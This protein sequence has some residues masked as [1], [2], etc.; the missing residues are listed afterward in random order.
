MQQ[1]GSPSHQ[2]REWGLGGAIGEGRLLLEE[3]QEIDEVGGGS[4][5][6]AAVLACTE[7]QRTQ[8]ALEIGRGII[9]GHRHA[10]HRGHR[11]RIERGPVLHRDHAEG[12]AD[13][14]G[15]V[16]DDLRDALPSER[17]AVG[18]LERR[19]SHGGDLLGGVDPPVEQGSGDEVTV[20]ARG[21]HEQPLRLREL[22]A[23]GVLV[24]GGQPGGRMVGQERAGIGGAK[25]E[26]GM[27]GHVARR[28]APAPARSHALHDGRGRKRLF[29]GAGQGGRKQ[30]LALGLVVAWG[31]PR[32][33]RWR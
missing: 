19:G 31:R 29:S 16:V 28:E 15:I 3:A 23:Q 32:A 8:Q 26:R 6:R 12:G 33:P 11:D 24:F 20:E 2:H 1:V 13:V 27:L 7:I 30:A 4:E 14:L 5:H 17:L 9:G 10:P 21:D 25:V 18:L 22:L